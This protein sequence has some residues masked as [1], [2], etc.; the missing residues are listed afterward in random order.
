VLL[1]VIS[2]AVLLAIRGLA[3]LGGGHR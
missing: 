3:R 2:L 1:L